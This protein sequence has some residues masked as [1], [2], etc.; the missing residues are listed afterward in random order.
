MEVQ[1]NNSYLQS[2]ISKY[3]HHS[4]TKVVKYL[5][6][7]GLHFLEKNSKEDISLNELKAFASK[8]HQVFLV[9]SYR[10]RYEAS[11]QTK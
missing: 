4:E 3:S 8:H 7:L 9:M 10:K 2:F 11:N 5:A 6:I 1:I